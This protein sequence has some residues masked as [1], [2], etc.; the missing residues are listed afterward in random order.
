MENKT[1][2]K[3]ADVRKVIG[4]HLKTALNIEIFSITYA[5]QEGND[6]NVNVEYNIKPEPSPAF[7]WRETSLFTIDAFTGDVKRFEKGHYWPT[8]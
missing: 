3:F 4:E 8:L 1:I 2:L 6:W 7:V 5:K